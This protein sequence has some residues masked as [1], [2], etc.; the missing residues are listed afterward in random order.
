MSIELRNR[1]KFEK[2]GVAQTRLYLQMGITDAKENIDAQEWLI[3]QDRSQ[4]RRDNA[5]YWW[6]VNL[7]FIAAVGAVIAAWPV[8]KE[9]LY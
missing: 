5:R 1:I 2:Q 6:V 9:W 4:I 3:E 7:A 8:V